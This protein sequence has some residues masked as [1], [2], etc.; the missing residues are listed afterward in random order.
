MRL[1]RRGRGYIRFRG[2]L[3]LAFV[4]PG[5]LV[6]NVRIIDRRYRQGFRR[7]WRKIL[8]SGVQR[9]SGIYRRISRTLIDRLCKRGGRR[10]H[11]RAGGILLEG[12]LVRPCLSGIEHLLG[13][14]RVLQVRF[15]FL[16]AIDRRRPPPLGEGELVRVDVATRRVGREDVLRSRLRVVSSPHGV[17]TVGTSWTCLASLACLV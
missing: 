11:P 4:S 3:S 9:H 12:C 15:L 7:C 8:K 5:P 13:G 2:R 10:L 17:R 1:D 14:D 6:E 16:L